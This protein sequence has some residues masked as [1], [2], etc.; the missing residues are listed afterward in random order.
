MRGGKGGRKENGEGKRSGEVRGGEGREGEGPAPQYFGLVLPVIYTADRT[1]LLSR[2]A[3]GVNWA[4]VTIDV[5]DNGR[6]E[7][8]FVEIV[9]ATKLYLKH[10]TVM[11]ATARIATTAQIIPSYSPADANVHPHVIAHR[12]DSAGNGISVGSAVF[13]GSL[14]C[15][16]DRQYT[17]TEHATLV[18]VLS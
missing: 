9:R 15:L 14:D 17:R 12:I 16:T 5:A 18:A 3:G 13:A 1:V 6:S 8:V 4:L 11:A 7:N 2:L 10:A